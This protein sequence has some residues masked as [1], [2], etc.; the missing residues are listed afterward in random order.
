MKE[1]KVIEVTQKEQK[2]LWA[3]VTL[4]SKAPPNRIYNLP[5]TVLAYLEDSGHKTSKRLVQL[6]VAFLVKEKVLVVIES[7]KKKAPSILYEFNAKAYEVR[8]FIPVEKRKVSIYPSP[9]KKE[10]KNSPTPASGAVTVEESI[11]PK[12]LQ[13]IYE[14]V[15]KIY[16]EKCDRSAE[17]T[18]ELER[19]EEEKKSLERMLDDFETSIGEM[20]EV[21]GGTATGS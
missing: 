20:K 19:V 13:A 16:R 2:I 8:K 4:M 18:A 3:I 17:L 11:I 9:G 1:Q 15:R 6:F 12:N 7:D 14:G 21:A 5:K 10:G